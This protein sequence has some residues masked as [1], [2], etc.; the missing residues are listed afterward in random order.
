MVDRMYGVGN[1]KPLNEEE[2]RGAVAHHNDE[3]LSMRLRGNTQPTKSS[4]Q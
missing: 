2:A 3:Q 1:P 4:E